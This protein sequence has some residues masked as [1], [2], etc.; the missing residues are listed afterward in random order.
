M[1]CLTQRGA[2]DFRI[3]IA[4]VGCFCAPYRVRCDTS[5][6]KTLQHKHHQVF[7]QP[8]RTF[9]CELREQDPQECGTGDEP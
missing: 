1:L 5:V 4:G 6:G 9:S 8:K 7:V 3:L 2:Q